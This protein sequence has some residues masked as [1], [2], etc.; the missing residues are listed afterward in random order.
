MAAAAGMSLGAGHQR[1]V[2][3]GMHGRVGAAGDVAADLDAR[4]LQ[5][6]QHGHAKAAADDHV[7]LHGG[8]LTA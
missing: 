5:Q 7:H 3:I 1:A 6:L 8:Q 4:T 2:Q